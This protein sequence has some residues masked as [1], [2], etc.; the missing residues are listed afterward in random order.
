MAVGPLDPVASCVTG[1]A[2]VVKERERAG[3]RFVRVN[4]AEA[5]GNRVEDRFRAMLSGSLLKGWR[6]AIVT[7]EKTSGEWEKGMR[8][9]EERGN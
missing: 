6:K 1:C 2:W 5:C 3:V 7:A 4:E 8:N 9:I